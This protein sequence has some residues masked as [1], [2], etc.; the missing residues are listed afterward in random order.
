MKL[1]SKVQVMTKGKVF[2]GPKVLECI[3]VVSQNQR[4]LAEDMAEIVSHDPDVIEWRVD[5]YD[6]LDDPGHIRQAIAI[7]APLVEKIPLLLTFRHISEGG[8]REA[9]PET[10]L[11]IIRIACQSGKIDLVDVE[12]ANPTQ[13]IAAVRDM[14]RA[15]GVKLVLS[16]HDF[17]G[18]PPEEELLA[19]L[20]ESKELGADIAK[21]ATMPR[22][23]SDVLTLVSATRRARQGG[24]DIPIISVAMGD[25][26]VVT[27]II[28]GEM[29][30]DMTFV[31]SANASAPGQVNIEDYR[32]MLKIM[33]HE[34]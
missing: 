25:L 24:L 14:A 1:Q 29:G 19:K 34:R 26:G 11:N 3:P 32:A 5:H 17:A 20:Q 9:S 21:I 22:S 27:R 8:F 28:G 10:R 4:Q 12:N 13:F 31:C 2:G 33:R 16:Y 15:T 23:F 18:T 6:G 30:T 7:I